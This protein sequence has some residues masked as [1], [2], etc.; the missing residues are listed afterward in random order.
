MKRILAVVL[1]LFSA[2]WVEGQTNVEISGMGVDCAG[3]RIALYGYRDMLT[4]GEERLDEAV[5]GA[6]GSFVLRCYVNY[7]RL[8]FLEVED[9]SQSF[10]VEPGRNY[11]VV[12]PEFD[13]S[14]DERRN[15][16][17]DPVALPVLFQNVDSSELNVRI[18]RYEEM[19]KDYLDSNR[20]RL[21]FRFRPDGKVFDTLE[22]KARKMLVAN[23]SGD[24]FFNRYVEYDLL[25]MRLAMRLDSRKKIISRHIANEPVRYHDENYMR[26]FFALYEHSVSSGMRRVAKWR[27]TEWVK[28]GNYESFMDS[29]G[30]DPLLLNEQI[31]ELAALQS[32]KEAWY[33]GDYEREG[34]E[35]MVERLAAATKFEEHRKLARSLLAKFGMESGK[36]E[37]GNG[38]WEVEL[39][40]VEGKR[41][42]LD[43]LRG[44]WVYM[45]FVRVGDPNCQRELET[46][47]HF[48]DSVYTKYPEV[49]F[50]TVSCD[51]EFQ[52]MYRFLRNSRRGGRYN[53][54]WLHFD[55][56]YRLLERLGV[57]SYPWFIL[58]DPQGRQHYN[59]TPAPA[60]GFLLRG[61]WMKTEI[62]ELEKAHFSD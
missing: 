14:Q 28:K 30:L 31:R 18:M 12:I 29:I 50:V 23:D 25:Q 47:A 44:K 61:P 54:T 62:P 37:V 4:W 1:L 19:V 11:R 49:V 3:K 41:V 56:D 22:T 27:M 53:W 16:Y 21:D 55:G 8:V 43:S 51:R 48:R 15:V 33:D 59:Y 5:F 60:S 6:D 13:W 24:L 57:V 2:L 39:P 58:L 35:R 34:V 10:Y 7:P 36:L 52:K 20:L 42:N 32:L 40:D 38:K 9:Y 26:L 45:A 17:L 46:M